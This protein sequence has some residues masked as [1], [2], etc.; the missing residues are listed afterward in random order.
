MEESRRVELDQK[1]ARL[2]IAAPEWASLPIAEKVKLI[3]QVII[4]FGSFG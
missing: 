4:T 3:D 1:I 2:K